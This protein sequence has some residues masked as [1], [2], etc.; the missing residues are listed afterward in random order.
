MDRDKILRSH[1]LSLLKGGN[2]HIEFNDVVRGFPQSYINKIPKHGVYSSWQLLEHMRISQWDILDFI[3]NPNYKYMK[4]PENYWPDK[5]KKATKKEWEQS[6]KAFNRDSRALQSIVS[7]K[8]TNL[9]VKIPHG[10]GQTI[11]REMLLVADH[12]AY[13]LGELVLMKRALG[14]WHGKS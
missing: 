4:W 5:R 11:L 7:S 6:V 13:H 8:R 10:T 9:Y 12:N 1:L 2:A 3:R 14:I